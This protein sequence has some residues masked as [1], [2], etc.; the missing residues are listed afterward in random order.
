MTAPQAELFSR[1]ARPYTWLGA[2]YAAQGL[3]F[4]F[5]TLALPVLLRE[6]GW[7][8]TAISLLQF[9]ALPWAIKF[10]W[11]PVLDHVGTRRAWLL[12]LQ[13]AA[14]ASALLLSQL[15][16]GVGSR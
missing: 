1:R 2:L 4:G 12:G 7:S 11:A 10:M 3:P 5:F 13:F 16:L 15:D 6:A 8:L 9:L 14:C